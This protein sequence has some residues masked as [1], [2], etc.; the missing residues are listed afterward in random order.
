MNPFEWFLKD[1]PHHFMLHSLKPK[2]CRETLHYYLNL[3]AL[4]QNHTKG[5][6]VL[7]LIWKS[8]ELCHTTYLPC[9]SSG[10]FYLLIFLAV[11]YF[12]VCLLTY[13]IVK[14]KWVWGFKWLNDQVSS[15]DLNNFSYFYSFFKRFSKIYVYQNTKAH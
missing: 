8:F 14:V 11:T 3:V 10:V 5:K 12:C 13:E 7:Q 6:F 15:Y 9:L 4:P 2:S 1:S